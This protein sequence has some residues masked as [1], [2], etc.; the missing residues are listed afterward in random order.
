ML[1][2]TWAGG[3]EAGVLGRGWRRGCHR[4]LY[5]SLVC[6]F[7]WAGSEEGRGTGEE[8]G[9]GVVTEHFTCH[10][11]GASVYGNDDGRILR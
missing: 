5:V 2:F 4:A 6:Y 9:G 7:A 8:D 3:E 1:N 10:F 11:G